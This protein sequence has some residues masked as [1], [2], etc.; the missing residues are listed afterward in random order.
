MSNLKLPGLKRKIFTI[1]FSLISYCSTTAQMRQVYVD[2]FVTDNAIRRISFISPSLGYVSFQDWI[3]FTSDSGHTFTKKYITRGNVDLNGYY[4][5]SLAGFA[6]GGVKTIDQK[7]IIAYGSYGLVPAI[8]RSADGGNTFKIVYYSQFNNMELRTGILDMIFPEN[9]GVGY[10]V[11][12]DRILKTTNFG[13]G[14][15]VARI[16]PASYFDRLE[17]VDNNT[18]LA[19]STEYQSNKLLQTTN[20]GASWK[21]INVSTLPNGKF[22]S[23]YFF[24]SLKGYVNMYDENHRNYIF[25]TINGGV[26]WTLQN[27]VTAASFGTSKMKFINDSVGYA[28]GFPNLYKTINSGAVWEELPGDGTYGYLNDL[29]VFSANQLW[30]GG[31]HGFLEMT[32]NGGGTP[33]PIAQFLIDTTGV[34]ATGKVALNNYSRSDY[35]YKWFKNNVIISTAYSPSYQHKND[36]YYDSIKLVVSN[37]TASD[38]LIRYQ[39]YP[40]PIPLVSA[41]SSVTPKYGKKG[42][43]ITITGENFIGVSAVTFGGTP[44]ISFNV[45]S[46]S[47]ISAVLDSGRSG[48]IKVVTAYGSATAQGFS[49]QTPILNSFT[50]KSGGPG[51]VISIIGENLF[52]GRSYSIITCRS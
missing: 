14:W 33:K 30:A 16:D 12:A 44:A 46:P 4:I 34:S 52:L 49:S 37:G 20:G 19:M 42:S 27:N 23:T 24:S 9:N 13:I 1:L 3:G 7:T 31:A 48:E 32:S 8:L 22:T 43:V 41:I 35:S 21:A 38:T 50:P 47:S 39:Y 26:S 45:I 25:K 36:E 51:T 2:T 10:A 18:V 28:L 5:N 6:I 15:S 17:A 29:Q 40:K 11:D